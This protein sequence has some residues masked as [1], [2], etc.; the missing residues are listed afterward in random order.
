MKVSISYLAKTIANETG[1][2]RS[3]AYDVVAK[4][5]G[6]KHYHELQKNVENVREQNLMLTD[7]QEDLIA[8]IDADMDNVIAS[9]A[10]ASGILKEGQAQYA[11][12]EKETQIKFYLITRQ[13][14]LESGESVLL[15]N[16]TTIVDKVVDK[17]FAEEGSVSEKIDHLVESLIDKISDETG[18]CVVE[19]NICN[20]ALME[21]LKPLR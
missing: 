1:V 21:L 13:L 14:K 2:N 16:H 12:V 17:V 15:V 11:K 3:K 4:A 5:L 10:K 8:R 19:H 9:L 20:N 18:W 7:L 6:K